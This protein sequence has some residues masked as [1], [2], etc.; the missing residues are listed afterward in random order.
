[1]KII[2][3]GNI[4]L[5]LIVG[6]FVLLSWI[7]NVSTILI[8]CLYLITFLGVIIFYVKGWKTEYFNYYLLPLVFLTFTVIF[9]M[10]PNV[11]WYIILG[12]SYN[13]DSAINWIIAFFMFYYFI[14]FFIMTFIITIIICKIKNE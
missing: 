5:F 10:V 2:I 9:L 6:F 3:F 13:V 11:F 8:L 4:F 1:M 7:F 14:P 12:H